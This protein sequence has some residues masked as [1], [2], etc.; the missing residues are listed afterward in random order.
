[1]NKVAP[2]ILEIAEMP[3]HLDLVVNKETRAP[4]VTPVPWVFPVQPV[5]L[6]TLDQVDL[7]DHK[8]LKVQMVIA[9]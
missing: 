7:R 3:D 1:M 8:D 4:P 5:K 6:A 2:V 9:D